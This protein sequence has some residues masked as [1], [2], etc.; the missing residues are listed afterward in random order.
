MA[1]LMKTNL[2]VG[3]VPSNPLKKQKRF[4][5]AIAGGEKQYA[6]AKRAIIK[7][8]KRDAV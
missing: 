4:P 3:A 6:K 1:D 2:K 8:A 7:K 5:G